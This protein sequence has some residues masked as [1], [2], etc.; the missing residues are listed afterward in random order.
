MSETECHGR[1]E[2]LV[3]TTATVGGLILSVVGL[4][5]VKAKEVKKTDDANDV[6]VKI[7]GKNPLSKVGGTYTFD[8]KGEPVIVLRKSATEFAAF[9]AICPHKGGPIKYNEKTQQFFCPWHNSFFAEDGQ[10]I[11]GPAQQ[12][13]TNYE[14]QDAVVVS[15]K[16]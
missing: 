11:S 12:P 4:E 10:R 8:Y 13:L 14:R 6:T 15:L 2:F 1:R 7:D 9:S 5:N 3:K 16:I